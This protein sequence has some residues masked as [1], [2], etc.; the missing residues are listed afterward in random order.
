MIHNP[1]QFSLR[2]RFAWITIACILLAP[3]FG[4]FR[5][6]SE[7]NKE[8]RRQAIRRGDIPPEKVGGVLILPDPNRKKPKDSN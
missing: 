8:A 4:L 2:Q 3:L 5:A 1:H 7:A 6:Q